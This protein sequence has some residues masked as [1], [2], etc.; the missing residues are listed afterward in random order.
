MAQSKTAAYVGFCFKSGKIT[1]GSGA[2]GALRYG[3]YLIMVD[4][5]SAKNSLRYALKYKNKFSCPLIV[6]KGDFEELVKRPL[7]RLAA[8]RDES[9][10][11]AIINSGDPDCELYTGGGE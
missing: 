11:N 10:A 8:I 5:K 7:A 9:L 1:V 2:V 3:V 6:Y 4:G